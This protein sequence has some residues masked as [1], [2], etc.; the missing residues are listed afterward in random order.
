[1]PGRRSA[2]AVG[3]RD[4]VD[5]SFAL[6]GLYRFLAIDGWS[7]GLTVPVSERADP[8][9][10]DLA[11]RRPDSVA[12]RAVGHAL[13]ASPD[14]SIGPISRGLPSPPLCSCACVAFRLRRVDPVTAFGIVWFLAVLAP[15]SSVLPLREGM[16]EHRVY[17]A[18]AGLFMAAASIVQRGAARVRATSYYPRLATCRR[19]HRP[20]RAH[21]DAQPGVVGSDSAL[22]RGDAAR[23]RHVGAALRARGFT[24]RKQVNARPRCRNTRRSSRFVRGTGTDIPTSESAWHRSGAW[25]KRNGSSAGR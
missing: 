7:N 12:V 16:A 17:L 15:S 21:G 6:A 9:T 14:A 24:A 19:R 22:E 11:L 5:G 8:V 23:R 13:G 10:R 2:E 20:V 18:S 1:M 3:G 25:T 4:P